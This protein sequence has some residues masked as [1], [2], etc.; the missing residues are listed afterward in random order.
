MSE[1]RVRTGHKRGEVPP[2]TWDDFKWAGLHRQ[3]LFEQYGSC[4]LLI[5]NQQVIGVG[6]TYHE[7]VADAESKLPPEVSEVTPI[8]YL[9][10]SP[11]TLFSGYLRRR[12]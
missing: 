3:E 12:R 8:T 2:N 5:Y 4:M 6:Q 9:L 10:S 7:L 1:S 11:Y